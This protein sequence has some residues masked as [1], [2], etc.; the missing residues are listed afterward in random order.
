MSDKD[1]AT[2]SNAKYFSTDFLS[3]DFTKSIVS[4]FIKIAK[5]NAEAEETL[6]KE[7]A[8]TSVTEAEESQREKPTEAVWAL[9]WNARNGSLEPMKLLCDKYSLTRDD[10]RHHPQ[11]FAPFVWSAENGHLEVFKFLC[12]KFKLP[13]K[14][15]K[16]IA[17]AAAVKGQLN[18]VQYLFETYNVPK[19]DPSYMMM[20]DNEYDQSPLYLCA[21]LGN[22]ETFKY[23]CEYFGY[24]REDHFDEKYQNSLFVG[25]AKNGHVN[26]LQFLHD[27]LGFSKSVATRT[28]NVALLFGAKN[29]HLEVVK[30]LC[31]TYQLGAADL[32]VRESRILFKCSKKHPD[33]TNYLCARLNDLLLPQPEK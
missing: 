32:L 14:W 13:K 16:T 29:G 21:C 15:V 1:Q 10:I 17:Y 8:E 19:D 33:I 6:N 25:A 27:T 2:A 9:S 24:S 3:T 20:E 18:V 5:A 28:N 26:V 22:V 11:K 12:A 30:Y 7:N 4:N 31:E 23:L